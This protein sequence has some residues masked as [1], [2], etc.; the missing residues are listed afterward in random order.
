M[1]GT[2]GI[3]NSRHIVPISSA[4]AFS[5]FLSVTVVLGSVT[6]HYSTLEIILDP[7]TAALFIR[8]PP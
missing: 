8:R 3:S 1:I 6:A 2:T 5:G 7:A 4:I